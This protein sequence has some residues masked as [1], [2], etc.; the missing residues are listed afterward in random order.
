MT[1][2]C[3]FGVYFPLFFLQELE[4]KAAELQRKEQALKQV[5]GGGKFV[6]CLSKG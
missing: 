5:Q 2:F 6:S 4:K 3:I 1:E